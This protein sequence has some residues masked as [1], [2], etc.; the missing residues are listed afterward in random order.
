MQF[1]LKIV[2]MV[3]VQV[4]MIIASFVI[5]VH[6][7]SQTA[8][9]GNVV[10]VAGKNRALTITVQ[11]EIHKALL[12]EGGGPGGDSYGGVAAALDDLEDNILFL[13]NGGSRDS[14]SIAPLADRFGAD[15]AALH[16]KFAEYRNTVASLDPPSAEP[17]GLVIGSLDET[18]AELVALSDT[19]TGKLG[20][21]VDDLSMNLVRL[22]TALGLGNVVLHLLMIALILRTFSRHAD[23]MVRAGRLAAVGELA[24][25]VAHDMKNPLGTIANAAAAVR[26][27]AGGGGKGST[28]T[29][30]AALDLID[31]SV[32]RMS[33]QIDGVLS[34][35]RAVPLAVE[36]ASV[37]GMLEGALY[38]LQVPGNV[39]V[40]LPDGDARIACDSAKMEFVFSNILLNAIQAM[41]EGGGSIGVR[42]EPGGDGG[43]ALHFANSGPPIREA[44]IGMVFEP[45]FTTKM[46][47]TG[48]GLTSCKN[49]VG[50]H[51]GSM[52][53]R[54]G[55]VTFT[56][57]LPGGK[58]G[59]GNGG[60]GE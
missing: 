6:F 24:S 17:A 19:L 56:V 36:A 52:S 45:L 53:A 16:A 57:R 3:G 42:L 13:R 2:A 23:Q 46:R 26:K 31:R 11:A 32:M 20:R 15:W 27:N 44:D 39:S 28:A 25:T 4:T 12:Y 40:S 29:V 5:I 38:S 49:I 43:I 60:D 48:L 51:G 34:H 9:A 41:G 55:P 1:R 47:G 30:G 33:H 54:N 50:Q 59:G 8:M 14:I 37:R 18:N 21:D 10:N 35:A 22:Q 58:R 7:E